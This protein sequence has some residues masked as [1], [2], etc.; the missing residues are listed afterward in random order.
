MENNVFQIAELLEIWR[1][2]QKS[3]L[4]KVLKNANEEEQELFWTKFYNARRDEE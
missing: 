4:W 3:A 1:E 2:F